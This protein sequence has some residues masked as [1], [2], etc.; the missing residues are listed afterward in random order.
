MSD[1]E[2]FLTPG[3]LRLI[4][5]S[6]MTTLLLS[7]I[8][9]G[10][11]FLAGFVLALMRHP[12]IVPFAPACWFAIVYTET[13]RRI[14]FLVKLMCVFFAYQFAG[15]NVSMFTVAAT[16]VTL[17]AAAFAS[18]NVRAGLE[19]IHDNQWDAAETMNM[20]GF[21]ALRRVILPQ[22]WPV[23]IPPSM[24]YSV[25]LVK[26]TSIASQIG[27]FE[28]TYAARIMNNKGISAGLAFGT[29]LILYFVICYSL[30]RFA[31]WLEKR[32]ATSRHR[33]T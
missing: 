30:N 7:L 23:M 29:I 2:L 6:F 14:P 9:C 3:N 31:A 26:S 20:G 24:T 4:G 12:R 5:Q 21:T 16:T 19:S 22:S 28:L 18:E 27:L 15:A 33:Q 17:S 11:G 1:W 13:F 8:G 25:G 32:L 10:L